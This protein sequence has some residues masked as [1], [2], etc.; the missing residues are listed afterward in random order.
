MKKELVIKWL[1]NCSEDGSGELCEECPFT[2][3]EDCGGALMQAAADV[4]EN[5]E[6]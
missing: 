4:I 1:H 5:K 3:C 6:A 2:S